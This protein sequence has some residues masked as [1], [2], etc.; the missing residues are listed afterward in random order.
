MS[1][2]I[3]QYKQS[4]PKSGQ[5]HERALASFAGDGAT[6]TGRILDPYRP[7]ITHAK[8]SRKWDVDGNEY[9]DF[10]TGHGSLILGHCHPDI[11][12]AIQEQA[13]KGVH[14]GENHQLEI[15]WAELIKSM[16]P[17]AQRVEFF[18]CGNEANMMAMRLCRAFTGK[19]KMLKFAHHFH[20]WN[21]HL[22]GPGASGT[23]SVDNEVNTVNIP[24]HDLDLLEKEL[25]TGQ[26]AALFTEGGG[27]SLGGMQPLDPEFTRAIP[28]LCQKYGTVWVLDEVVTGFRDYASGDKQCWQSLVGVK[29]DLTTT[30]KCA[31]GGLG[32]GVL[33]GRADIMEG[34]SPKKG[35]ARIGHSGT[36][37]GNP[38]TSAAGIAACKLYT[39]AEPQR[40]AAENAAY[41]RKKGN[42]YL[43]ANDISGRLYSR[44]ITHFYIGPIDYEPKD[45]TMVPT[46]NYDNLRN[47]KLAP[48]KARLCLHLLQRGVATL[49]GRAFIFSCV[50]TKQDVD[51]TINALADSIDAMKKDGTFI[52]EF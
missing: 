46:R 18:P 27:A 40:I 11:V 13:A 17:S 14:F 42:E 28:A 48:M 4:H 15:E 16:V 33:M 34:F 44:S 32:A 20:G 41:F 35:K 3:E 19:Q 29:P 45:D 9:I 50:H 47:P 37:N 21:D 24:A 43:K 52:N 8:G 30:G 10:V 38:L 6:H 7:Y 26:Y 23:L 5:L 12:A 2:I 25:K 22:T 39:T 49:G 1:N 31:G 36:W 51:K